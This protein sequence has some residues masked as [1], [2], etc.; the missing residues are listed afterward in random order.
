M[1][2]EPPQKYFS[3]ELDK[4]YLPYNLMVI[5]VTLTHYMIT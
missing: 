5:C 4:E 2:V 3:V 1:S